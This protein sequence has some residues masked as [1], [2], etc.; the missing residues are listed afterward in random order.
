MGAK[1]DLMSLEE[2]ESLTISLL[3]V[4]Q[5]FSA[6]NNILE[7]QG[8]AIITDVLNFEDII[9]FEELYGEDISKIVSDTKDADMDISV[10]EAVERFCETPNHAKARSWPRGSQ[11]GEPFVINHGLPYGKFPW[12]VRLQ[13]DIKWI[14]EQVYGTDDIITN[15]DVVFFSPMGSKSSQTVPYTMHVDQNSNHDVVGTNLVYQSALYIWPALSESDSTTVVWPRS[16]KTVYDQIMN[17]QQSAILG[18]MGF[19]YTEIECLADKDLKA[20]L[21]QRSLLEAKR[22]RVPAGSLLMWNSKTCHQ[23]WNGGPRLAVP[24]CWEPRSRRNESTRARKIRLALQSLPTTHWA[25]LGFQ[26][27]LA[28]DLYTGGRAGRPHANMEDIGLPIIPGMVANDIFV[29]GVTMDTVVVDPKLGEITVADLCNK[30]AAVDDNDKHLI[31]LME[32]LLK[33]VILDVL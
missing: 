9:K 14:Y 1:F 32:K 7:E 2:A 5:K 28:L 18:R 22:L 31:E 33:P 30:S 10:K 27:D 11:L 24:V 8:V 15:S 3:E 19:H 23:G 21:R 6:L 25:S 4:K 13:S 17:D 12:T 16:H 20:N 26:H 29:S